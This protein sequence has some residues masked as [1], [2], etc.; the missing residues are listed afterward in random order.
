MKS[1]NNIVKID[2][3][4]GN[5]W[6]ATIICDLLIKDGIKTWLTKKKSEKIRQKSDQYNAW[7][8]VTIRVSELD[9]DRAKSIVANYEKEVQDDLNSKDNGHPLL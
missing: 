8:S 6:E 3:Y 4:V 5:A 9:Y 1:E 7:D 2:A